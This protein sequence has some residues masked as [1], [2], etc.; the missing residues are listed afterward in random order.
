MKLVIVSGAG[1]SAESGI[2]TFRGAGGLYKNLN[3]EVFLS[4]SYYRHHKEEVEEWQNGLRT[5]VL[6]ALPNAAHKAIALATQ[7]N[8]QVE[9]YTQNVDNLLER[10]GALRVV[11]VHGELFRLRCTGCGRTSDC[12]EQ[13]AKEAKCGVCRG[14]LR[15]DVVLFEEPVP[16]HAKLLKSVKALRAD[17]TLLVVGTQGHILPIVE[18]SRVSSCRKILVDPAPQDPEAYDIVCQEGAGTA[19]PRIISEW[20]REVRVAQDN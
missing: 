13:R 10:A 1:L 19:V 5:R 4:A 8:E 18:M 20:L 2:P 3:A 6:G 15:T 16:L 17:D 9:V 11:H 12:G 7:E 14:P